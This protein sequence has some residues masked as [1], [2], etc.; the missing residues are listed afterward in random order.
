MK[1]VVAESIR[2][3]LHIVGFIAVFKLSSFGQLFE[4]VHVM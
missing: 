3:E 4:S 1:R 2:P